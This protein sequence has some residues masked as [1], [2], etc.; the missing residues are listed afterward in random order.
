MSGSSCISSELTSTAAMLMPP[1]LCELTYQRWKDGKV[2]LYVKLKLRSTEIEYT[3]SRVYNRLCNVTVPCAHWLIAARIL[4]FAVAIASES[5]L[6]YP[7]QSISA[8][9][10]ATSSGVSSQRERQ[11]DIMMVPG[12]LVLAV[13]LTWFAEDAA[14]RLTEHVS[15]STQ[16]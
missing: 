8:A 16:Q 12:E 1:R 5:C 10:R 3:W 6:G 14:S 13:L 9:N 2:K 7:D 4:A 11:Q 15:C